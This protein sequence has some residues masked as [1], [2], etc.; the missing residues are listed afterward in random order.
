MFE[1]PLFQNIS[2][3]SVQVEPRFVIFAEAEDTGYLRERYTFT[4]AISSPD[5]LKY[6]LLG[7]VIAEEAFNENTVRIVEWQLHD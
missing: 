3:D 6:D 4:Y 7:W 2:S 1:F 5:V